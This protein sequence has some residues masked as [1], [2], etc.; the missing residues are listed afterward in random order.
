MRQ[1]L[2]VQHVAHH[3]LA[4]VA[5][6]G[7]QPAEATEG[8]AGAGAL[9]VELE[10]HVDITDTVRCLEEGWR[11]Q[12]LTGMLMQRSVSTAVIAHGS[13][14]TD[15]RLHMRLR[16]RQI[17]IILRYAMRFHAVFIIQ[18]GVQLACHTCAPAPAQHTGAG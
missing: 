4:L 6:R 10:G 15:A 18:T 1:R 11:S 8:E 17:L 13:M 14:N 2:P 16:C 12:M 9:K 5:V 7:S 3:L